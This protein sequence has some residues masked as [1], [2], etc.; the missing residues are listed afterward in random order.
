MLKDRKGGINI[1]E[2]K[3]ARAL[4][5]NKRRK[6]LC[7]GRETLFRIKQCFLPQVRQLENDVAFVTSL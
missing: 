7:L 4:P 6:K 2:S 1:E 5:N 3:K